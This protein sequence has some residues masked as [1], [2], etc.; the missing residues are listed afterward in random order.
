MSGDLVDTTEMYLKAI[1][2]LEEEGVPP[3]RARLVERLEQSKPT[4]SETVARLQRDGLLSIVGSRTI[5]L[6]PEGRR[7]AT[8]VMR[9]HR[10]AERLLLDVL[11]VDWVDVHDEAC[12]WEH[13]ISDGVE[14]KIATLLANEEADP[15]GN[16]IPEPETSGP[17]AQAAEPSGLTRVNDYVGANP[18]GG[19][20]I[21]ARI[22]EVLQ[23]DAGLLAE[24]QAAGF[25]PN[26]QVRL[27]RGGEDTWYMDFANGSTI[28]LTPWAQGH[29]LIR[30]K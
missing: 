9:K 23:T 3:L 17:G 19:D 4:V 1:Y 21:L 29:L 14:E 24:F 26:V 8:N 7:Q 30:E 5:Q 27:T 11:N 12:R 10:L 2:E 18:E 22:G 20:V 13:V 28:T 6:S 15:F 25:A 16:S